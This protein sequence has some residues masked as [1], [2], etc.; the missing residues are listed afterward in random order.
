MTIEEFERIVNKYSNMILR[1]A[2]ANLNHLEDAKDI[3]QEVFIKLYKQKDFNSEEHLKN[4]LIR[5]T[6]NQCRSV[7]RLFY[8]KNKISLDDVFIVD[9]SNQISIVEELSLLKNEERVYVYL[10]YI[11]GYTYREIAAL[12]NKN[13]STITS[14]IRRAIKKL[15]VVLVEDLL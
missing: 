7:Q 6:I 2:M 12:F 15:K 4:W 10:H 1:I 14:K 3:I 9:E 5:V 11:E 8:R 13:E